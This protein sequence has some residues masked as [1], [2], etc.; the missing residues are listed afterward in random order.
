MNYKLSLYYL[1]IFATFINALKINDNDFFTQKAKNLIRK[2]DRLSKNKDDQKILEIMVEKFRNY[3]FTNDIHREGV[4]REK[5]N[6]I[7][8]K[9]DEMKI[10]DDGTYNLNTQ[11]LVKFDRG[12]SISFETSYETYTDT[13]YEDIAYKMSL[14]RDNNVYLGVY[15]SVPEL[16][17]YF[18]DLELANVLAIVF[19]QYSI[20]D[21]SASDEIL[22]E[23][24]IDKSSDIQ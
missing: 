24:F 7:K 3:I 5:Y 13:E 21:W 12:Y 16:S 2:I 4:D 11:E 8:N 6:G 15:S 10:L 1:I 14:L 22:N 17:F 23:Y 20:W 9:R 18:E 19:N